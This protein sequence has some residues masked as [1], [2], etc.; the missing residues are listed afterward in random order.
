M[1]PELPVAKDYRA[2]LD[3]MD[4]Q[5]LVGRYSESTRD[6]YRY[7]FREFLKSVYPK[8]LHQINKWDILQH[9]RCLIQEKHVSSSYQNQ[10][11]NAIKFYL[12]QVLGQDRQVFDLERPKRKK[13]LPQVLS[14]EEVLGILRATSNIKHKAILTTIYAAGLR[15]SEVLCMHISDIDS[16]RMNIRIRDGKGGKDRITVLSTNL[17]DLL[18]IYF[19]QYR[20]REFLFEGPN[21]KPYSA[22]S[23]RKY[24][25]E[26]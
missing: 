8:P 12:E 18:R 24:W 17:L 19:R 22:G 16:Q 10:S 26:Q 1:K 23:V 13:V 21:G 6:I 7:M 14:E 2:A 3:L 15:V 5:L 25:E 4:T 9:H 20:P 11:I